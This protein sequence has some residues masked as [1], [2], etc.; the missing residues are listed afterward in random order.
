[1]WN[2]FSHPIV[3]CPSL[4]PMTAI[5]RKPDSIENVATSSKITNLLQVA[6]ENAP[7]DSMQGNW[8]HLSGCCGQQ[9]NYINLY[10]RNPQEPLKVSSFRSCFLSFYR[11]F[12]P[13]T[14]YSFVCHLILHLFPLSSYHHY[15]LFLSIL[16]VA[17]HLLNVKIH[18]SLFRP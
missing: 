3:C 12:S 16:L 13:S 11:H 17:F 18:L 1:M 4:N 5:S 2:T 7:G 10:L 6:T 15:H 9:Q 8:C 14:F